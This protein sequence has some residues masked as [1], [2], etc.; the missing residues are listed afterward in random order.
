MRATGIGLCAA[1]LAVL[2]IA[3]SALACGFDQVTIE[4]TTREADRIVLGTVED[5][6]GVGLYAYTIRVELVIKGPAL[7]ADW[8]IRDAGASDCGMP[9]LGVG[10]RFVLEYY[11]PG[12]I[13]TG[14][15]FY[16]WRDQAGR[17]GGVFR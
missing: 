9:A 10:Q 16:A 12:R 5:R 6:T 2:A 7:P 11:R 8:V 17:H 14:P 1:L 3:P 15:W 4:R 13:T